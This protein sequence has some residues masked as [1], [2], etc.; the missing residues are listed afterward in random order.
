MRLQPRTRY[1]A[2]LAAAHIS[3]LPINEWE[4]ALFALLQ[5]LETVAEFKGLRNSFEAD[6]L[7]DLRIDLATKASVS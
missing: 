5:N 4:Q 1:A 2:E 7:A 3:S 6:G